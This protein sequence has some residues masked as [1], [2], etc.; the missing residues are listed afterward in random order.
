MAGSGGTRATVTTLE[1]DQAREVAIH[2]F[3]PDYEA[4]S[5]AQRLLLNVDMQAALIVALKSLEIEV[6]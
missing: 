1:L 4:L 3:Q 6:E 5:P 2:I